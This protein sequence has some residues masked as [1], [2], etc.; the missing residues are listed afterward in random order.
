MGAIYPLYLCRR[1]E[2]RWAKQVSPLTRKLELSPGPS[3]GVHSTPLHAHRRLRIEQ[4]SIV[5]MLPSVSAL[6][7]G[8]G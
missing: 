1:F 4:G 8:L 3:Q 2:L 6:K 5:L 7:R